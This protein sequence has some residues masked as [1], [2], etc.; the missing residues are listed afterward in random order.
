M[1]SMPLFQASLESAL[2][3]ESDG[4]RSYSLT[5]IVRHLEPTGL[6]SQVQAGLKSNMTTS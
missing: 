4:H 1:G 3:G 2:L 5:D 6:V